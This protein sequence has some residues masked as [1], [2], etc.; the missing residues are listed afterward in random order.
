MSH[1]ILISVTLLL[2]ALLVVRRLR[3]RETKLTRRW[4]R[5]M[6]FHGFMSMEELNQFYATH[7]EGESADTDGK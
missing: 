2:A 7:P 1:W 3:K 4:A 6:Y 5:A